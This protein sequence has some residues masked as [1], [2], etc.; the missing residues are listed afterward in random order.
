MEI[1]GPISVKNRR[2]RSDE[3]EG[4]KSDGVED[5]GISSVDSARC[6]TSANL[7]SIGTEGGIADGAIGMSFT[8]HISRKPKYQNS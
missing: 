2:V 8:P 1:G 3:G 6:E 7:H 4:G 5:G